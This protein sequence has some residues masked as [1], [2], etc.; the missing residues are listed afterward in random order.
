M[1]SSP[2]FYKFDA[3]LYVGCNC[4]ILHYIGL[5]F[6]LR[7]LNPNT[8]STQLRLQLPIMNAA[9]EVAI[10][11]A[12]GLLMT[13]LALVGIFQVARL[14]AR[15]PAGRTDPPQYM[16]NGLIW[17]LEDIIPARYEFNTGTDPRQATAL[18]PPSLS[19]S[20]LE[21]GRYV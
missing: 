18:L 1:L 7:S 5:E 6:F 15:Y 16:Q 3:C 12:F 13:F 14:A 8:I 19:R 21:R 4:S 10:G 11:M 20:D 9:A 17:S 2:V